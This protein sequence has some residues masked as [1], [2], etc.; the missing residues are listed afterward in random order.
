MS[1]LLSLLYL[2]LALIIIRVVWAILTMNNFR[3]VKD[4]KI[5][6]IKNAY[7]KNTKTR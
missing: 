2:V 6:G 5:E 1:Y 7:I 3:K 4:K